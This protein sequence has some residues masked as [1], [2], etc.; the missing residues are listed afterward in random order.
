MKTYK[1]LSISLFGAAAL[2]LYSCNHYHIGCDPG[3]DPVGGER[4]VD[5]MLA[6]H[7]M[8]PYMEGMSLDCRDFLE[9]YNLNGYYYYVLQNHC[10]DMALAPVGCDST[11]FCN[12]DLATDSCSNFFQWAERV[13]IVG[14]EPLK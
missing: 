6:R 9:E 4:C 12:T 3:P 8:E 2:G 7:G 11:F 1:L 13:G 14:I 5:Q 10:K